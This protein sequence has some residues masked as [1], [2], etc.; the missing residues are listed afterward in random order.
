MERQALPHVHYEVTNI[1]ASKKSSVNNDEAHADTHTQIQQQASKPPTRCMTRWKEG[2]G[3]MQW[4]R[5]T[6]ECGL[7]WSELA[8]H[9]RVA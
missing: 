5:Q 2:M 8:S 1:M 4:G 6:I 9:L 3:T 7:G